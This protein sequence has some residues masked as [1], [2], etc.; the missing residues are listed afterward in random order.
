MSF[1]ILHVFR[2]L[3]VPGAL[4][5][6]IES[7]VGPFDFPAGNFYLSTSEA[8]K[9]ANVIDD[10]DVNR[11]GT[12]TMHTSA[13]HPLLATRNFVGLDAP[14][15]IRIDDPD[16]EWRL[17]WTFTRDEAQKLSR[18]IRNEIGA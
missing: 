17:D 11:C 5:I 4:D 3:D 8:L 18:L 7:K 10:P 14:L 15:N 13:G 16:A 9:L 12:V 2:S 6:G 1:R